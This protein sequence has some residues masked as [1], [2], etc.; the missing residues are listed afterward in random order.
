M[1][2]NLYFIW[3]DGI[4]LQFKQF[5]R[6]ADKSWIYGIMTTAYVL[7]YWKT[8]VSIMPQHI[9]GKKIKIMY[10]EFWKHERCAL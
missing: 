9:K 3:I 6:T 4:Y 7:I 10:L 2:I 1:I 8:K 5:L